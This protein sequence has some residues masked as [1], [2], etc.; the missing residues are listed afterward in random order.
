MSHCG[1]CF[2]VCYRMLCSVVL[3]VLRLSCRACHAV[4][5]LVLLRCCVAALLCPVVLMRDVTLDRSV[6]FLSPRRPPKSRSSGGGKNGPPQSTPSRAPKAILDPKIWYVSA[7]ASCSCV[8]MRSGVNRTG[9]KPD[10]G[11]RACAVYV[12][13]CSC[14]GHSLASTGGSVPVGVVRH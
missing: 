5:G 10:V 9:A 2:C 11:L 8:A 14:V 13:A 7:I 6:M 1:A 3:V 12:R 4:L